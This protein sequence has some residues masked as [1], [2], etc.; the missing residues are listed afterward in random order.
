MVH[1]LSSL[2]WA[3]TLF[4][5]ALPAPAQ[6]RAAEER[7]AL[8][9]EQ[10]EQEGALRAQVNPAASDV[11]GLAAPCR[12]ASRWQPSS[13]VGRTCVGC[14]SLLPSCMLRWPAPGAGGAR[15]GADGA[16][17]AR[18]RGGPGGLRQLLLHLLQ[19]RL[20]AVLGHWLSV[21]QCFAQTPS[22]HPCLAGR[23]RNAAAGAGPG[24]PPAGG[25]APRHGDTAP[26]G[27]P[28]AVHVTVMPD[29]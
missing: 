25:G 7:A 10:V 29:C 26:A 5:A 2:K 6:L 22:T 28:V 27:A 19:S 11:A 12:A 3:F 9:A 23:A 24:Q 13:L 20:R 4:V 21:L 8:L 14:N 18:A 15:G 17:G 1:F 16:V